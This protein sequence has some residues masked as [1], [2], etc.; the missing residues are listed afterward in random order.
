MQNETEWKP[1]PWPWTKSRRVARERE[2]ERGHRANEMTH[3]RRATLF[4]TN[5][6]W[7]HE[8]GTHCVCT[9]RARIREAEAKIAQ[10]IVQNLTLYYYIAI[11]YVW[12]LPTTGY[13]RISS[14]LLSLDSFCIFAHSPGWFDLAAVCCALRS[15]W[16][17]FC[18][19]IFFSPRSVSF[20]LRSFFSLHRINSL[21]PFTYFM[22]VLFC[23]ISCL[24]AVV[25]DVVV[26]FAFI[27]LCRLSLTGSTSRYT[28]N[29]HSSALSAYN[30][31]ATIIYYHI[32][33]WSD[34][35]AYA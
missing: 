2:R 23:L 11:L 32:G 30:T 34:Q 24:F 7:Q 35:F 33:I 22:V 31:Y 8:T 21:F 10:H 3:K 20:V 14:K 13:E 29:S 9:I 19:D 6:W 5:I 28:A 12:S 18:T 15:S 26:F 27:F 25:V 16:Y 4:L 17:F 1:N